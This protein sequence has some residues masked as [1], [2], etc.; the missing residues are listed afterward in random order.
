[1]IVFLREALESFG[2]E[3]CLEVG[4]AAPKLGVEMF[5]RLADWQTRGPVGR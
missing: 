5:G 4:V 2:P 1:V 3:P